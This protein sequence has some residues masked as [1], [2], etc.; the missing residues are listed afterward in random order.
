MMALPAVTRRRSPRSSKVTDAE[1]H[2]D[3]AMLPVEQDEG[4][5]QSGIPDDPEHDRQVDPET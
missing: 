5:V 2:S 3:P 4:P 1:E